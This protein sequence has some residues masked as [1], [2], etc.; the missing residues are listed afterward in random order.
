MTLI[1]STKFVER[2]R[3]FDNER[4]I[5]P[6]LQAIDDFARQMRWLHNRSLH[7]PGVASGYAVVGEKGDREVTIQPGYAIDSLGREIVLTLPRKQPV[8]PQAGDGLGG[9]ATFDLTVSYPST[10]PEPES[11]TADCANATP[12]AVRLEESPVFCWVAAFRNDPLRDQIESGTRIVLGRAEVLNCQLNLRISVAQRSDA[13]PGVHPFVYSGV[14][15]PDWTVTRGPFGIDLA[16]LK[17][18]T[19][20]PVDTSAAGFRTAPGYFVGLA[21]DPTVLLN[22]K[23]Q[24]LEV[25]VSIANPATRGFEVSLLIPDLILLAAGIPSEDVQAALKK[26]PPTWRIEW[27]GVEA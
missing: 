16:P 22:G 7:Q 1:G 2:V 19:P 8:P 20:V 12:G 13:R 26:H 10:L 18:T 11:R 25:F 14:A 5:A 6:D 23:A 21:D 27:M 24:R 15:S 17:G 3:F 9:P 4:L